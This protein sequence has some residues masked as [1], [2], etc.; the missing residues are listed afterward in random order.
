MTVKSQPKSFRHCYSV[1]NEGQ[2]R[3]RQT[4]DRMAGCQATLAANSQ[5]AE[6]TL[7]DQIAPWSGKISVALQDSDRAMSLD[8]CI[9]KLRPLPRWG[10]RRADAEAVTALLEQVNF[11]RAIRL[12]HCFEEQ[13]RVLVRH[14]LVINC[15]NDEGR[16]RLLADMTRG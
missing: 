13:Q 8:E 5:V 12:T 16:R 3:S 6:G 7:A 2:N 9:K 11:D 1:L 14:R 4:G 10:I 15:V